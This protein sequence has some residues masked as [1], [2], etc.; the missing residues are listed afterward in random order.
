LWVLLKESFIL[1]C[2]VCAVWWDLSDHW[3]WI[4]ELLRYCD[5]IILCDSWF[6]IHSCWEIWC[7]NCQCWQQDSTMTVSIT[8]LAHLIIIG[9]HPVII[10]HTSKV[11]R[12]EISPSVFGQHNMFEMRNSPRWWLSLH[13]YLSTQHSII[14]SYILS[15]FQLKLHVICSICEM[16]LWLRVLGEKRH[17]YNLH[18]K[19]L[20]D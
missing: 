6:D 9:C 14:T 8:L 11:K 12:G 7:F 17:L 10:N 19:H 16:L 20:Y 4:C 5:T 13:L 15:L 1:V 3:L 2:W 18:Q